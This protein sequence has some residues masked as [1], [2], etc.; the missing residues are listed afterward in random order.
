MDSTKIASALEAAH[1]SPSLQLEHPI[2]AEVQGLV[3]KALKPL[4]PEVLPLIPK[5]VLSQGSVEY[6]VTTREKDFGQN[7]DTMRAEKGG[8]QCFDRAQAGLEETAALLK[9]EGGPF[10]LGKEPCY[11]DF[12]WIGFVQFVKRASEEDFEKLVGVD[13]AL[14]KQYDACAK[15]MEKDD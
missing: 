6:W 12:I 7:L 4:V 14:R 9:K 1:P 2:V 15:Y 10:F 5:H 8:Q 3:Y 13:D 11:A